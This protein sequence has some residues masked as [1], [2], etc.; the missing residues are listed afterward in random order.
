MQPV[1]D[2][3]KSGTLSVDSMFVCIIISI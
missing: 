2:S 3:L 1:V